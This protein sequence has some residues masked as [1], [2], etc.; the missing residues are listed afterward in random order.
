MINK[1]YILNVIKFFDWTQR[2]CSSAYVSPR[3]RTI[4]NQTANVIFFSEIPAQNFIEEMG[5]G[6]AFGE[7]NI[8]DSLYFG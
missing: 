1:Q 8:Q 4:F 2:F 6:L 5:P 3:F 7:E